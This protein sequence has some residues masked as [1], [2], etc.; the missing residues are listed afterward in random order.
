M[1]IYLVKLKSEPRY[2]PDSFIAAATST[3]QVL[4]I[5]PAYFKGRHTRVCFD[6]EMAKL[7]ECE[8]SDRTMD[9]QWTTDRNNLEVIYLGQAAIEFTEPTIVEMWYGYC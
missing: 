3:E 7:W 1:N 6:A 4:S 8:S 2:T 9:H 5:H